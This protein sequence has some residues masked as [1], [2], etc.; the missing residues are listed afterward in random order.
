MSGR[1][2]PMSDDGSCDRKGSA[3]DAGR[4]DELLDPVIRVDR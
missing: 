3:E 1:G 2:E 4:G